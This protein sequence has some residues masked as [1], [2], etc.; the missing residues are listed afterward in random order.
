MERELSL[1]YHAKQYS[2]NVAI[3]KSEVVIFL[4]FRKNIET[5]HISVQISKIFKRAV[6]SLS[7]ICKSKIIVT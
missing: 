6:V 4:S 2:L 1:T 3:I 7:K 5:K